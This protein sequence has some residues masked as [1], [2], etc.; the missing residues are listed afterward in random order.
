MTTWIQRLNPEQKARRKKTL[1]AIHIAAKEELAGTG[2]WR[3]ALRDIVSSLTGGK[4]TS[5]KDCYLEELDAVLRTI[6]GQPVR[7]LKFRKRLEAGKGRRG[8]A[9]MSQAEYVASLTLQ[10]CEA[11]PD[12]GGGEFGVVLLAAKIGTADPT[13]MT[14]GERRGA[15]SILRSYLTE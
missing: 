5:C 4:T 3:E 10:V 11:H 7:E 6:K 2:D 12:K 15:I 9:T 13:E 8:A 1:A 14:P